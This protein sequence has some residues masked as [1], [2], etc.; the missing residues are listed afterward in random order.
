MRRFVIYLP[1]A[2]FTLVVGLAAYNYSHGPTPETRRAKIAEYNQLIESE[3]PPGSSVSQVTFFLDA[4]N[5][6]HSECI[7]PPEG[8]EVDSDFRKLNF[9]DKGKVIND[10]II[11]IIRNVDYEP[12]ISWSI[13]MKFYFDRNERLLTYTVRWVGTGP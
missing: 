1:I 4:H 2:L 5:I 3:A 6:E 12:L 9:P 11:A 10:F 8:L 13:Q 7:S